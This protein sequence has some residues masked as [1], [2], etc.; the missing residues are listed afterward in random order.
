MLHQN[1]HTTLSVHKKSNLAL[2]SFNCCC[3]GKL[4]VFGKFGEALNHMTISSKTYTHTLTDT[5][6]HSQISNWCHGID[7][8]W[9]TNWLIMLIP[10]TKLCETARIINNYYKQNTHTHSHTYKKIKTTGRGKKFLK[11]VLNNTSILSK[12]SKCLISVC[13]YVYVLM[14]VCVCV[15]VM[16][17]SIT[18][19][20]IENSEKYQLN[21]G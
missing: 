5:Y 6:I 19:T 4:T 9:L 15:C 1:T 11:K 12:E 13:V 8:Y 7:I 10:K 2:R 17:L 18:C 3:K 14:N 21:I 20:N 16:Q